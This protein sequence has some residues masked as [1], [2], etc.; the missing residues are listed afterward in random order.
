MY[1]PTVRVLESDVGGPCQKE[2]LSDHLESSH[3]CDSL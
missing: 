2:S 1:K 3:A